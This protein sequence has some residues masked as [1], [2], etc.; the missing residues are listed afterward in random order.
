MAS[1]VVVITQLFKTEQE[2]G[3]EEDNDTPH[4]DE[5]GIEEV[6]SG[7]FCVMQGLLSSGCRVKMLLVI[8][9]IN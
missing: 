6:N 9:F 4:K 7:L 2:L 5:T 3:P 1:P 8:A